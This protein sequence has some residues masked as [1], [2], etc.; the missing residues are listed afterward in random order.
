MLPEV[1]GVVV[2]AGP[3]VAG[4]VRRRIGVGLL[5]AIAALAG[6]G[7]ALGLAGVGEDVVGPFV[8]TGVLAQA[9]TVGVVTWWWQ[10]EAL[11]VLDERADQPTVFGHSHQYWYWV[12][13]A[14]PYHCVKFRRALERERSGR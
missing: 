12:L 11:R 9:A 4:V 13:Y 1:A 8:V 10:R 5:W 14:S 2:G 3:V 7:V 6:V